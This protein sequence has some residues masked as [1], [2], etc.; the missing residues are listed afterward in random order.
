MSSVKT[1]CMWQKAYVSVTL[2]IHVTQ[3]PKSVLRHS[4]FKKSALTF[5]LFNFYC[6]KVP[7]AAPA[8]VTAYNTSSVG[9]IV[10][11]EQIPGPHRHGNVI[12]FKVCYKRADK[13][14]SVLYCT[15]VFALGIELGGLRS[16]TPYWITVLGFTNKGDG[17]TSRPL[18]VWTD[19]FGKLVSYR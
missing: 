6:F 8:N 17:P 9:I 5:N 19:E 16:Y 13:S 4:C 10:F 2:M 3:W 7:T 14:D 18:L 12:G 1:I 11:W 15:A